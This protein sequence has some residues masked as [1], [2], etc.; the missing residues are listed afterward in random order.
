M[1]WSVTTPPATEP[2]ALADA[3][4]HLRVDTTADDT[5]IAS[6]I[7]AAREHVE[8]VCQRALMPQVWTER[9]TTFPGT[10]DL[11][12][13]PGAPFGFLRVPNL[14]Q[15]TIL[16]VGGKVRVVDSVTYVDD[17]GA[18]QTLDPAAYITDLTT[19][20]AQVVPAY[21]T[22]WPATREQPGAVAV[23]YQVGYAD[24]NSVPAALKAAILLIL[25][26]L[27]ANREAAVGGPIVE[28]PAVS[29][30]LDPYKRFLP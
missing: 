8:R 24:A 6:L 16:L 11:Q 9:R 18:S 29:R 23:Q 3:K 22:S 27:Y 4:L 30:L 20:P 2:V 28:N 1:A 12:N 5:L 15:Q 13:I 10:P 26:D 25:A 19:E 14:V 21:G 7:Q 17:T